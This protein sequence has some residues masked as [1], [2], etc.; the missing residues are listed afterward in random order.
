[1][2]GFGGRLEYTRDSLDEETAG[3]DPIALFT[4]WFA[5]AEAAGL[6]EPNAMTL[7]TASVEGIPSARMVLLRGFDEQ[8][9]C[10][11][12]NYASRKGRE[13][14]SN[15]RAALVLFWAELERQVRIEGVV[16]RTEDS[17]SDAYFASRPVGAR[18]GAWSS[19]Q[20]EV[21]RDRG[22]LEAAQRE[23][24][25]KYRDG[26]VPRPEFWGGYRLRPHVMEFWQGRLSRLHDR[27]QYVRQR[28]GSWLR[29]R[30]SP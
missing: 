13:L 4:L 12:T 5:E 11:F 26:Q 14:E 28:D 29:Q 24:E 27:L 7:A 15:P 3:F 30:L 1:M 23:F 8:G 22:E 25:A 2:S 17:V 10:F 20:S 21:I 19:R 18:I 6:R 9:F 16:S